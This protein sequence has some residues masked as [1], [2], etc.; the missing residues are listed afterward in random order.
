[1]TETA[2][3]KF[4]TLDDIFGSAPPVDNSGVR[5]EEIPI[6]QLHDF[7]NHPFKVKED[8]ALR[9]MVAS[10]E[11]NGVLNPL[12]VRPCKGGGYEV[13]SGHRRK[14]AGGLAGLKR[15]P[16]IIKEYSDDEAII[17]MVDS[18]LQRENI[19]PSER[20][21]AFKM[22]VDVLK[23]QAG[24]P[25]KNSPRLAANFRSD[26]EVAK[27][28]GISGDTVRRYV[29]LTNLI[30]PLLDM[31]DEKRIAFNP[32][33]EL[34]FLKEAEQHFLLETIQSED[35]TPSLSQAQR[36]KQLSQQDKLGEDA[37]FA[38]LTEEKP[39]QVEKLKIDRAKIAEYIPPKATDKEVQEIICEAMRDWHKKQQ[40]KR[41]QMAR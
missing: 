26:D 37:V 6:E 33:V 20:A 36:L 14:L 32:A 27:S 22:K 9:E 28:V 16:V 31:V 10:V 24:R 13:I 35:A 7:P 30:P 21:F 12:L 41:D 1:M 38:V 4:E 8:D 2:P 34:S 5:I 40:R 19:L 29:N 25:S 23:R 18:N 17:L 15:I 39:N 3:K 11:E